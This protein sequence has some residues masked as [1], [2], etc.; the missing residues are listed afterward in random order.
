MELSLI[1]IMT[2]IKWL[3][4]LAMALTKK[5]N[6]CMEDIVVWAFADVLNII[7]PSLF[8][9]QNMR[10]MSAFLAGKVSKFF[11]CFSN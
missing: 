8:T 4:T 3:W 10:L 9:P 2:S 1:N 7:F 11:S 5:H 6:V